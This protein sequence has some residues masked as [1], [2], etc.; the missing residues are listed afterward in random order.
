MRNGFVA[1]LLAV[2]AL[3]V[4]GTPALAFNQPP[5]NLGLTDILDAPPG[6]GTYFTEYIQAYQSDKFK[7]KDGN[8]IPGNPEV[9]NVLSMNQLVH[10][11]PHKILGGHIGADVLLPIVAISGSGTL[12]PPIA[13]TP[14]AG[15]LNS[16]TTNP[17]VLGDFI[18]GPFLQWFDTKLLGRPFLQRFE[19]DFVLPTGQYDEK[20]IAN[21]GS[22]LWTIEPHYAFVWFLTPQLST[23]WRLMYDYSTEND[24]TKVKPG[25]VFHFNYSFEYELFKNFR[26]AVA[27][28][29][30]KQ[31]TEDE[32]NGQDISNS[33]EQVFAIGPAVFWAA[34][35]NFF[36]GL[37]TQWETSTE[38]RPEGNRTTFRLTYKF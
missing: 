1:L 4:A 10:V 20:Y 21:P 33:E 32:I 28:Y 8:D 14:P 19:L 7:D 34:S 17:A 36:L 13:G 31:V 37:K 3:G 22:N 15:P 18:V 25:Q 23:S 38:N 12:G 6:P 35:P 27:G 11:Y 30:L 2:L 16:F 9:A 5:L 26:G 29:Y 24:D